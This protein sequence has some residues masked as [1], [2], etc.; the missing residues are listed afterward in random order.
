[1]VQNTNFTNGKG[2]RKSREKVDKREEEET[3]DGKG[4]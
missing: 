4:G 3:W 2:S 1:M